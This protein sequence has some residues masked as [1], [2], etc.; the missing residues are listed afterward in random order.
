MKPKLKIARSHTFL[1]KV[2]ISQVIS[3]VSYMEDEE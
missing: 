3:L 2:Y 1:E